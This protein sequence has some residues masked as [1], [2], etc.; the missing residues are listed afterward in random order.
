MEYK[1]SV[2]EDNCSLQQIVHVYIF[3]EE[4]RENILALVKSKH[5]GLDIELLKN[6]FRIREVRKKS[7]TE[8]DQWFKDHPATPKMDKTW[9]Q[10]VKN[11]T[12]S[13]KGR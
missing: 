13:K 5:P 6:G 1:R 3:Q 8:K 2:L 4:E 10:E 11:V 12:K 9:E 7:Q